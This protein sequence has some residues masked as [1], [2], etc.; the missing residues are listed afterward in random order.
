M[1]V[2]MPHRQLQPAFSLQLNEYDDMPL[3]RLGTWMLTPYFIAHVADER[4][5]AR[6]SE[7]RVPSE[8]VDELFAGFAEAIVDLQ[9]S[10]PALRLGGPIACPRMARMLWGSRTKRRAWVRPLLDEDGSTNKTHELDASLMELVQRLTRAR[11]D[12]K[13]M[14]ADPRHVGLGPQNWL[15]FMA[16]LCDADGFVKATLCPRRR[17]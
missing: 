2:V 9:I 8:P 10:S 17:L 11:S 6:L 1:T 7:P 16:V 3:Y 12:W 5:A 14:H 15:P 4:L 13:W